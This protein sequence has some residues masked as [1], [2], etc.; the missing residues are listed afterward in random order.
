MIPQIASVLSQGFTSQ[1]IIDYIVKKF[2]QHAD[3][4]KSAM[5]AGYTTDQVL[6]YLSK[7][8][9]GLYEDE[10]PKTEYAKTLQ[11][12]MQQRQDIN[13]S[14]LGAGGM[15]VSALAAP[16]AAN[17]LKR[18]LPTALGSLIPG[19]TAA[20]QSQNTQ[21]QALQP[22]VNQVNPENIPQQVQQNQAPSAMPSAP[23][24]PSS[25]PVQPEV[26]NMPTKT[27][28]VRGILDKYGLSQHVDKL[29]ERNKDPKQIAAV[30][31]SRFPKEMRQFQ[32]EAG[33]HMEDAIG[34]YLASS[35]NALK[36]TELVENPQI[37]P[38]N[39]QNPSL[40]EKKSLKVDEPS[41]NSPEEKPIAKSDIVASP[42]GVG[43]VKEI[44]GGEAVIDVDGKLHKVKEDDLQPEPEEVKQAKLGFDLKDIP[45]DLRSAPLNEVYL[46]HDR[47][48]ITVKYNAGLKPI[49][50]IYF[51]KDNKPIATDYINKI[52]SGVQL[53]ITSGLN[54]WG[55]WD[56]S[57]SDSRGT[58]N[59]H[60][61]VANS[62]EE[63]E[64]DDPS[65]DYWF[66][67][68]EALYEHPYL[69]KKG[70]EELRQ[71][72][73]EFNEKRKKPRKKKAT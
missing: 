35:Q 45:E 15:A 47:R 4:I 25:P 49:R 34:D 7:D 19:A 42:Q 16:M 31:Y 73:K 26:N 40:N 59:Y 58:A 72:E 5:A 24:S 20:S 62:Q 36:P 30:L 41:Y 61:L 55:A 70:K 46:P 12:D 17:A 56:S 27:P 64:P 53:P 38:K 9:K 2:P 60:E 23:I 11:K 1:Q 43:E 8:K 21:Q 22:P 13:Q 29:S 71:L 33:K 39:A 28:D 44:R 18:A 63:G 65:K 68:E 51:R 14:A 10:E 52:V 57:K 54:F 48:H 37:S 50:Y 66:I 32:D 6:K 69:E 3:K 67:K